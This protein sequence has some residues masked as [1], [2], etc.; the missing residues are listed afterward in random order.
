MTTEQDAFRGGDYAAAGRLLDGDEPVSVA[1]HERVLLVRAGGQWQLGEDI[2]R[3]GGR[4][5]ADRQGY[6][7]LR[8]SPPYDL[9]REPPSAMMGASFIHL[10]IRR[11]HH[12]ADE[13]PAVYTPFSLCPLGR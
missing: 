7:G 1:R 4:G 13:L 12:A 2:S 8:G 9:S 6:A 11:F 3:V 10:K 5:G